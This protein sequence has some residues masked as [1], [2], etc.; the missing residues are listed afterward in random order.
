MIRLY[1]DNLSKAAVTALR[2][3]GFDVEYSVELNM[4]NSVEDADHL[5]Y[6]RE[7]SRILITTDASLE[8][9]CRKGG[10]AHCGVILIHDENVHQPKRYGYMVKEM[11]RIFHDYS[12]EDF[13][14]WQLFLVIS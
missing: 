5:K 1:V 10:I 11:A 7:N 12:Q 4:S 13:A 2:K 9:E 8:A 3:A 14:N 6:A